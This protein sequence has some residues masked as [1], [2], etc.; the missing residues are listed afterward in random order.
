M[1]ERSDTRTTLLRKNIFA[2]FLVKGWAGLVQLLLVPVTLLCLGD[3]QNG[4]WMTIASFLVWV[5]S[6]DIGLGNGLRNKLAAHVACGDWTKARECVSSTF[7]MLMAVILPVALLLIILIQYGDIYAWMNVSPVL[8]PDLR[9]VMTM[10]TLL[11]SGIFILKLVGNIYQGLQLPAVNNA[12]VVAGQTLALVLIYGLG[13]I[14][15]LSDRLWWVAVAYTS[16]SLAVYAVAL[17]I[18]FRRYP[19]LRPSLKCFRWSTVKEL[20][21]IGLKF[22]VIQ[23]AGII[24]FASS[25]FLISRLLT[26]AMVTPYQVAYR[27]FSLAM[28][29]FSIVAVPYW[30]AT[31]DAYARGDVEWIRRSMRKMHL[32]LLGIA[33]LLVVMTLVAIPIYRLWVGSEVVVPMSLSWSMAAYMMIVIFSLSYSYFLNG[34]NALNLQLLFTVGAALVYIPLAWHLGKTYGVLGIVLALCLVNLPGAVVNMIQ[35]HRIING[36]ARGLWNP[37]PLKSNRES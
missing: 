36:R 4:I 10:T 14:E 22:F 15:G 19:A 9:D 5:E 29:L 6:F 25:N 27:Y 23:V 18:T 30:S 3:Y 32:V 8:V 12:L 33:V 1:A 24:L 21:Q 34:L 31:T 35:Y 37:S 7:L 13:R 26:P 16:A 28:M 11:V 17:P 20:F 2:S